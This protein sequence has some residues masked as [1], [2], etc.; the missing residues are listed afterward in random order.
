MK[1]FGCSSKIYLLAV[2]IVCGAGCSKGVHPVEGLVLLDGSPMEEV[3]V[4]LEPVGDSGAPATGSTRSD[5][6]FRIVSADGKGVPPGEYAVTM[7]KVTNRVPDTMPP[8]GARGKMPTPDERAKMEKTLADW[9]KQRAEAKA[10][11][12]QWVPDAYLRSATTPVRI[13]VPLAEKELKIELTSP[14][15]KPAKAPGAKK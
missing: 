2:L 10:K 4:T 8:W 6:R 1:R 12:K 5:G 15:E 13:K 7:T 9:Q 3:V 11:E 14:P